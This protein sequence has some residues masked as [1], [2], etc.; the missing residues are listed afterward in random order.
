[1]QVL[2]K[3]LLDLQYVYQECTGQDFRAKIVP[4]GY[5]ERTFSVHY[6]ARKMHF[7]VGFRRKE[8]GFSNFIH[9]LDVSILDPKDRRKGWGSKVFNSF[10]QVA[11]ESNYDRILLSPKN[12]LAKNFGLNGDL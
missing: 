4:L 2:R 12:E 11:K 1:M 5:D 10:L 6:L 3:R 8:L 9:I 7:L